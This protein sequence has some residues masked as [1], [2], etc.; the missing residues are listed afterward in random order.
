[1]KLMA[2]ST[3]K[4]VYRMHCLLARSKLK[5]A[6][7]SRQS[8]GNRTLALRNPGSLPQLAPNWKHLPVS[9]N[10]F[11]DFFSFSCSGV[12]VEEDWVEVHQ[13]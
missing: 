6:S 2:A 9:P 1:M 10:I 8:L 11:M 4:R 7:S 5:T 12:A 3:T 13:A